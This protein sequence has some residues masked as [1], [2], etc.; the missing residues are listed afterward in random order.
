M[1][2]TQL[3]VVLALSVFLGLG[4]AHAQP[5]VYDLSVGPGKIKGLNVGSGTLDLYID[6]GTVVTGVGTLCEDGNGDELCAVDVTVTLT[7]PGEIDGFVVPLTGPVVIFEPTTFPPGTKT[8]RLNLLQSA[9]P[10]SPLIPQHLGTV[11][12]NVYSSA[13][14]VDQVK[15]VANGQVVN[16][17]G[18]LV[19]IPSIEVPEPSGFV[20]LLSGALGLAVLHWLRNRGSSVAAIGVAHISR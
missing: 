15:I 20:L 4:S 19:G 5:A 3:L 10:P 11:S 8:V 1:N 17:G 9:S 13:S 16:A 6:A 12:V 14:S 2:A 7:G 18:T